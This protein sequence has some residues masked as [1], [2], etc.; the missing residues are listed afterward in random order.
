MTAQAEQKAF[1]TPDEVRTF[2]RG[3]LKLL[4]IGGADIGQLILRARLALV[5]ARQAACRDRVV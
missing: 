5:A 2:E 4:K 1:S 3:E